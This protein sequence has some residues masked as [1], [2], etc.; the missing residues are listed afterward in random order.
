M[1]VCERESGFFVDR[2]RVHQPTTKQSERNANNPQGF[3]FHCRQ[4]F[5]IQAKQRSHGEGG[6]IV[7]GAAVQLWFLCCYYYSW[8]TPDVL[9]NENTWHRYRYFADFSIISH[10]V[11]LFFS[12]TLMYGMYTYEHFTV[13]DICVS[14]YVCICMRLYLR[15][16]SLSIYIAIHWWYTGVGRRK[17]WAPS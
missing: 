17:A 7:V 9:E 6:R 16:P 11:P 3:G 12:F 14:A 13:C 2:G 4:L 1:C 10:Y 5:F 8:P 15:S